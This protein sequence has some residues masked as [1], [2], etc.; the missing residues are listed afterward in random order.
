M[1]VQTREEGV[2]K[3]EVWLEEQNCHRLEAKIHEHAVGHQLVIA[4]I[5]CRLEINNGREH[6]NGFLDLRRIR[7]SSCVYVAPCRV[8]RL[9]WLY[10]RANEER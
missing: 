6:L 3:V 1:R 10:L 2:S 7:L 8:R 5:S 9:L 4:L